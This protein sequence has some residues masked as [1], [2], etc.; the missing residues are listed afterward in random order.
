MGNFDRLL[1]PRNA[2]RRHLGTARAALA[3]LISLK[4]TRSRARVVEVNAIGE[5]YLLK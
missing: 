2:D 3:I 5:E 1:L 4:L